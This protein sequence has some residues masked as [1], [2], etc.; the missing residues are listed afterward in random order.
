M[1]A[2]GPPP[3]TFEAR[4]DSECAR[5]GGD[6]EAG[7]IVEWLD[8]DVVHHGCKAPFRPQPFSDEHAKR[9]EARRDARQRS[10]NQT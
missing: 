2:L 6:I 1:T 10:R 9:R 7:D 3:R 5:C 8:D 4:F